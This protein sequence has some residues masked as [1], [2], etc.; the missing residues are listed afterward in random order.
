L[1]FL[2]LVLGSMLSISVRADDNTEY[3]DSLSSAADTNGWIQAIDYSVVQASFTITNGGYRLQA[4]SVSDNPQDFA[5]VATYPPGLVYTNFQ[6]SLDAINWDRQP[7]PSNYAEI[8][9]LARQQG[10][11]DL[12]NSHFYVFDLRPNG[13]TNN[14]GMGNVGIYRIDQHL[15]AD[16]LTNVNFAINFADQ[17]RLVFTG[18]GPLLTGQ[19]FDLTNLAQPVATLQTTDSTYASG[20]V[21]IG[22]T[23]ISDIDGMGNKPV[24]FTVNNF[25]AGPPTPPL[26]IQQSV[27]LSW[28]DSYAGYTLQTATNVNGPWQSLSVTPQDSAGIYMATVPTANL[29]QFF[30][31]F[32]QP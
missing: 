20:A 2:A 3:F 25:R 29:F 11:G 22:A 14:D 21:G 31:L 30:R 10:G 17:Y 6:I 23:D 1:S 24:D 16:F 27:S 7:W 26:T 18:V 32:Y 28:P 8:A 9:L 19:L 5:A 15:V 13:D 12:V 4:D